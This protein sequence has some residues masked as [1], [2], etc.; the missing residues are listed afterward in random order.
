MRSFSNE[1]ASV[2]RGNLQV[3]VT[4]IDKLEYRITPRIMNNIFG[5]K[6]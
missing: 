3:T 5:K 1:A 6:N 4:E 2:H